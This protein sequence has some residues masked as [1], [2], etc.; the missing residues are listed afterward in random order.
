[1]GSQVKPSTRFRRVNIVKNSTASGIQTNTTRTVSQTL[2]TRAIEAPAVLSS[3]IKTVSPLY[4]D[5]QYND[6]TR[7]NSKFNRT[8][9]WPKIE[10]LMERFKNI[11]FNAPRNKCCGYLLESPYKGDS[12][13]CPQDLFLGIKRLFMTSQT[14]LIET[15]YTM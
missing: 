7:Y 3:C 13:K 4:T 9:S 14:S 10:K 8:D 15:L 2:M 5:I 6:Q 11:V 12:N 1:M